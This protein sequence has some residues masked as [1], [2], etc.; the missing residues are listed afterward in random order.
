MWNRRK[1]RK[2]DSKTGKREYRRKTPLK[3]LEDKADDLT[4]KI[5]R[6]RDGWICQKCDKPI[7]SKS[8]AHR[9]HIVGCSNKILRWDLINLLLM[10]MACHRKFHDAEFIKEWVWDKWP[11]RYEY[12]FWSDYNNVPRCNQTLP[13]RTP[14][15]KIEWMQKI[16]AELEA[17]YE[18]LKGK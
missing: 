13:Y 17:K 10:H 18:E 15:E 6:L 14:K 11:A 16:I 9:V 1:K 12:L 4:K 2:I 8:D 3:R 5:V 7:T